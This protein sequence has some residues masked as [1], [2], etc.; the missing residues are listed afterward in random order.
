MN[1]I[2]EVGSVSRETVERLNSLVALLCKWNPTI[3]LVSK[4]TLPDAWNR[5]IAD[6]A[7]LYRLGQQGHWVDIGSGGGFPGIVIAILAAES[8]TH[9]VTLIE[10]DQRK[11]TF[12]RTASRELNLNVSVLAQRIEDAP[13]QS[14][15]TLSARALAPL[16]KLL[17]FAQRHL[18][19]DGIALF[20]KGATWREE[21][22]AARQTFHF[23]LS[24]YPSA[25]EPSGAI[26]AVKAIT[27]A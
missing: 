24:T 20:P 22:E 7:Q 9:A 26:L 14:A 8:Q 13:P 1:R 2:L 16:P 12:L 17:M 21:V 4:N 6:S 10:S 15:D 27:N 3:N 11:A 18:M 23:D 25:T 19:P 5:H